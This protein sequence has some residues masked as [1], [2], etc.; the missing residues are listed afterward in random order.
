MH[1]GNDIWMIIRALGLSTK[2]S[3]RRFMDLTTFG[4]NGRIVNGTKAASF[5][6]PHQVIPI[7]LFSRYSL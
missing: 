3:T 4:L 2:H 7:C 1:S 5:Q 6:F